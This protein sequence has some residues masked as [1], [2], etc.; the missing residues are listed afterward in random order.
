MEADLRARLVATAAITALVPAGSILWDVRNGLPAIRLALISAGDGL[1]Y[2]GADGLTEA[3]VQVDCF[4]STPDAAHD[5]AQAVKAELHGLRA[6][7]LRLVKVEGVS[8]APPELD[9][10]APAD[11]T[12]AAIARRIVM[13]RVFHANT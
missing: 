11:G 7:A 8:G 9:T 1:T 13:V 3:L 4:A 6:N 2:T 5:I 12:P 10:A